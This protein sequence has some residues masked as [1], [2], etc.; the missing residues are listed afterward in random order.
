MA[1]VKERLDPEEGFLMNA[2]KLTAIAEAIRRDSVNDHVVLKNNGISL[3]L[4][5]I[6]A[7]LERYGRSV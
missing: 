3:I 6:A 7:D 5:D 1:E 4:E 2:I